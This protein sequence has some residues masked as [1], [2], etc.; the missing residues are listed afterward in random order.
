M[1]C[2]ETPNCEVAMLITASLNKNLFVNKLFSLQN[3]VFW[4][5]NAPKQQESEVLFGQ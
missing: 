3:K 2:H 4:A 1:Y 5:I